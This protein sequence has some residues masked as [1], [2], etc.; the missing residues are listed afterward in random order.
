MNIYVPAKGNA[1]GRIAI[2]GEA[3]SYEE[4]QALEPFVGNAGREL[5]KWLSDV[6]INRYECWVT[7]ICKFM[8]P[9]NA[10]VGRQ[11]PFKNRAKSVDIDIDQQIDELRI[12]LLQ[13]PNLN[14]IIALG[15][16]AL[17]ALTGKD[18]IS[19]YR[20]SILTAFGKKLIATYHP[21]H[22]LRSEG[23]VTGY[24]QKQVAIADLKRAAEQQWFPE[25]KLPSRGL[26]ICK[27]SAQLMDF[28]KRNDKYDKPAVDI[29]A[30]PN[31]SGI[32]IC[33]GF[34]FTPSEGI[35]VPLW[36]VDG[37]SS[38]PT[39]DLVQ[40]WYLA[41]KLLAE[42]DIVGQNFKYDQDK[43]R[44][45]GFIIKKLAS[46]TMLK[47]FAI[48]P[49]LPKNLA[50]N[51]SIYTLE[52]FYKNEGMYDGTLDDLLIGCAR[53]SCVTK[54]I[55][56]AMDPDIDKLGMRKYYENFIMLLHELYL[57]IE[58]DGLLVDE[59]RRLEL[60][61]KYVKWSEKLSYERFK[62]AGNKV[63][64]P[65]SWKQVREFIYE[66]LNCPNRQ[67][68]GEEVLT[69]LYN[70]VKKPI[71]KE[72]ITNVLESRRV[73]KTIGNY[74]M[75]L[76]DYDG[77]MKSTYYLCLETGRTSTGLLEPPIR[78]EYRYKDEETKKIKKKCIGT[79]FQTLT[80]H[81][82]IGQDIRSMY[83]AD[84]GY[85]FIQID[86]AQ[87]E[88]RVVFLLAEDY[89]ALDAIDTC[90]FH[91]RTAS[92]FV[93]GTEADWSKKVL[94]YEHPNRFLGKTLR[95][96]GHL[97]AKARR[98]AT[99]VNTQAR[100]YRIDVQIKESDAEIAL[101]IF[102]RMQ[103]KIKSNFHNG[104]IEALGH[105]HQLRAAIPYGIDADNAPI[106]TFFERWSDELFRQAFSY[107]PQRAVTDNTKAA[108]LRI[109]KE[110]QDA[111]IVVE[112][113]DALTL[114][115]PINDT[116]YYVPVLKEEMERPIDFSKC[117]LPR[118][119][120]IIPAE[121]EIADNYQ[122]FRRYKEI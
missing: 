121:V 67:G 90:D 8:V 98:A 100:K 6:G 105:R 28:I 44:R 25:L 89:D 110:I 11:I 120:L 27:S 47:A 21:A 66:Y 46:D 68:T 92:W 40:C 106:R 10:R 78:P 23:D 29:E 102:H 43:I 48:N 117:S 75:A 109:K 97:G 73:E 49:E 93:G 5:N 95:H 57:G 45:L 61:T 85:C 87:A 9:P 22:I 84:P 2:V 118:K 38:I 104:V 53:D 33:I 96:A 54:E 77:R 31:G 55:D 111:R 79:A 80:K 70:Q 81:G 114:L 91:A 13:L 108:A 76:P 65:Q 82:D 72:G 18:K 34:A 64:N 24:W 63:V 58:T 35:T 39:S 62:L 30:H 99:E 52:P 122:E 4:E 16:T 113:H 37:I 42:N 119:A 15:G 14:L 7:N 3:P 59:V 17:W 12:E 86:S 71:Q 26:A 32:P 41:A 107:I 115:V 51:T 36:N 112:S 1:F 116:R 20:G 74:L 103:P 19:D 94:G 101:S 83:V 56:L 60:I 88:T 50:F 69:S